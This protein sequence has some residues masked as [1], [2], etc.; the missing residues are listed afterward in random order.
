MIR[1][2][3]SKQKYN[4]LLPAA[5]LASVVWYFVLVINVVI[6]GHMIGELGIAATNVVVPI[7][8]AAEFVSGLIGMGTVYLYCTAVGE[9]DERKSNQI[10]GQGVIV[11]TISGLVMFGIVWLIRDP[12][13][14]YMNLSN[15]VHQLAEQ[16]W[17]GESFVV[18][19]APMIYLMEEMIYADGDQLLSVLT[20]I[21]GFIANIILSIVLCIKYGIIGI[22]LGCCAG[23]LVSILVACIHLLRKNNQLHFEWHLSIREIAEMCRLSFSDATLFI[24]MSSLSIFLNKVVIETYSEKYLPVL[25][26]AMGVFELL[27]VLDCIGEALT[28]IAEMYLGEKNYSAEKQVVNHAL[29]VAIIESTFI[30]IGLLVGARFIPALYDVTSPQLIPYCVKAVRI[31]AVSI[32]FSA[33]TYLITSQAILIRHVMVSVLY[34]ALSNVLLFLPVVPVLARTLGISGIWW[35]FSIV[36]VISFILYGVYVIVKYDASYFPW[37][38]PNDDHPTFNCSF[39]TTDS[40]IVAARDKLKSFL[41]ANRIGT[42]TANRAMLMVEECGR[43]IQFVNNGRSVLSEYTA[44]I[45]EDGIRLIIRSNGKIFDISDVDMEVLDLSSYFVSNLISECQNIRYMVTISF[46]RLNFRIAYMD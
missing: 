43:T 11:A 2:T 9:F 26:V 8:T 24:C 25:T 30:M 46:N 18:L 38:L 15:T 42:K 14:T 22:S 36:N 23:E 21:I 27:V 29:I 37:L 34:T 32:V 40:E 6:A 17:I 4:A 7:Y 1:R 44:C 39:R 19:L 33:V 10:Y 12:F 5:L 31:M 3:F 41:T 35:S 20:N 45:E 13:L 16:F 28:P